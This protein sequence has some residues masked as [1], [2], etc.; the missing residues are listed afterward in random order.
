MRACVAAHL[1]GRFQGRLRVL[2]WKAPYPSRALLA[3]HPVN[4]AK[5]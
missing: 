3:S 1:L 5:N 4:A 2:R